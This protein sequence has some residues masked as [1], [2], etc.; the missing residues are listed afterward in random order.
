MGGD[1][2][3]KPGGDIII[4]IIIIRLLYCVISC[5]IINFLVDVI[6]HFIMNI[7]Y[8]YNDSFQILHKFIY[9]LLQIIDNFLKYSMIHEV[10]FI[11]FRVE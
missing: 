6:F 11:R 2:D 10:K 9:H 8:L 7:C 1:H 5:F 4:I 3:G